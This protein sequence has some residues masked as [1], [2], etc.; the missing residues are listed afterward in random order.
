MHINQII[1]EICPNCLSEKKLKFT[2]FVYLFLNIEKLVVESIKLAVNV[3]INNMGCEKYYAKFLF[4]KV[5]KLYFI[6]NY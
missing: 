5:V 6:N 2:F 4:F 3:I 1:D